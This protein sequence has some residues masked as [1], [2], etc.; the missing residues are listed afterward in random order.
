MN[1][2]AVIAYP[3]AVFLAMISVTAYINSESIDAW[4]EENAIIIEKEEEGE[5]L[6]IQKNER[7]LAVLIDF[8]DDIVDSLIKKGSAQILSLGG[9]IL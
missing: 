3:L 4:F 8:N 1:M 5:L 2:K 7:W 6:P 9:K